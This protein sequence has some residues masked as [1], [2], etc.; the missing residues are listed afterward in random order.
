MSSFVDGF[1]VQTC[2]MS[3]CISI[4]KFMYKNVGHNCLFIATSKML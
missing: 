1:Y 2:Q 4:F 3:K